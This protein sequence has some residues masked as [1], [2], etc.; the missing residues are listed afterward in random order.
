MTRKAL[1]ALRKIASESEDALNTH[2]DAVEKAK[3]RMQQTNAPGYNS[4]TY[5]QRPEELIVGHSQRSASPSTIE[6]TS[7]YPDYDHSNFDNN[8]QQQQQTRP[9][10]TVELPKPD[11]SGGFGIGRALAGLGIIG[12]LTYAGSKLM[13]DTTNTTDNSSVQ[14]TP[15]TDTDPEEQL[16]GEDRMVDALS[17][18]A[19]PAALLGS[20]AAR[21]YTWPLLTRA[22]Q[23]IGPRALAA[24]KAIVPGVKSLVAGTTAAGAIVPTVA[25]AAASAGAVGLAKLEE[26]NP[27][28]SEKLRETFRAQQPTPMLLANPAFPGGP[29]GL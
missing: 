13:P 10:T 16:T 17:T 7:A 15:T 28:G 21:K 3:Y 22:A 25:A 9:S 8:T 19:G 2:F 20:W 18:V 29:F 12:G 11:N 26:S 14:E 27:A 5:Q 1:N 4:Y 23:A 24:A 6:D